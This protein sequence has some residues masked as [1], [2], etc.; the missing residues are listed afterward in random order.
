MLKECSL[1]I[2]TYNWP[3][4]LELT[5]LSIQEQTIMPSEVIIADDGSRA[6]TKEII[7]SFKKVLS[8]PVIHVWHEDSGF[9][10]A[11]IRNKAFSYASKMYIIQIDGDVI[12]HKR[13]IEDHLSAAKKGRLLQ[14]SRVL[15]GPTYSKKLLNSKTVNINILHSD[16][17]RRENGFRSVFLS[18]YLLT[19]YKNR[20]PEYYARG[21][22]MSFWLTDII[23]V[24]GYNENF[25]GWG[26]EDSDLTLRLINNGV[27][28][29]V[30]KFAAIVYHIYHPEQNKGELED[31]NRRLLEDALQTRVSW[32][33][34]GMDKYLKD[35]R[36]E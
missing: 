26:H 28:K 34:F 30:I 16:I 14:G 5:L 6:P 25:E 15:L 3:E 13:F 4:A 8:V 10:L 23:A 19:K 36:N 24:N 11:T 29:S 33:E 22:N 12:L 2:S 21:A 20:Y 35:G 17:A 31:K 32:T 9:K 1:I 7:D 27:K 18:N